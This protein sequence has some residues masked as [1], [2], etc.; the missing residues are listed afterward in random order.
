MKKFL[1]SLF[2]L[3]SL[4]VTAA[5]AGT[6]LLNN[7]TINNKK[8]V[9]AY[10]TLTTTGVY[11]S[12]AKYAG[13]ILTRNESGNLY[14]QFNNDNAAGRDFST[15]VSGG[16]AKTVKITWSTKKS[17]I[18]NRVVNIYGQNK[19]YT[20]EEEG[21][22]TLIGSA[23][24]G[25]DPSVTIDLSKTP[26]QYIA[27]NAPKLV[28]I[29]SI[30]IV[31][32]A[33]EKD[34]VPV[35]S[36]DVEVTYDPNSPT[37]DLSKNLPADLLSDAKANLNYSDVEGYV[38]TGGT[39]M[40]ATGTNPASVT[41]S[42]AET[43]KYKKGNHTFKV[44]IHKA[45]AALAYSAETATATM[46]EAAE[47]PT[48]SN[49]YNLKLRYSS[50]KRA[51][52]DID[53]NT[54]AVTIVAPG[55]ATIGAFFDGNELF[56]AGSA[57][58]TLT[59][60]EAGLPATPEFSFT[61]EGTY[62]IDQTL[63]IATASEDAEIYYTLDGENYIKYEGEISFDKAGAYTVSAYAKNAKGQSTTA[64]I[65]FTIELL[66]HAFSF[67]DAEGQMVARDRYFKTP[68]LVGAEGVNVVYDYTYNTGVLT[69]I[70]G[71][72]NEYFITGAGD[73]LVTATAAADAT[74]EAYSAKTTVTIVPE[75]IVGEAETTQE[76]DFVNYTKLGLDEVTPGNNV[77]IYLDAEPIVLGGVTMTFAKNSG[78]ERPRINV[79]TSNVYL[80]LYRESKTA[81]NGNGCSVTISAKDIT[82]IEMTV[83]NTSY[84]TYSV[85]TGS[86]SAISADKVYTWTPNAGETAQ[87]VEIKNIGKENPQITSIK[88]YCTAVTEVAGTTA[89]FDMAF[90]NEDGYELEV[91]DKLP[92]V[93][94][95]EG[96]SGKVNYLLGEELIS[97]PETFVFKEEHESY[98]LH[99]YTEG[100][101]NY[102]PAVA[103][104]L[105][106]VSDYEFE[107][108]LTIHYSTDEGMHYA[109]CQTVT[110]TDGRYEFKDIEVNGYDGVDG[111][112]YG[113]VFFSFYK[114][115]AEAAALAPR[116]EA[117]VVDWA[118]FN[119][120]N[121]IYTPEEHL[122]MAGANTTLVRNRANTLGET[123]PAV[124]RV[125]A[126]ND[127]QKALNFTV[128]LDKQGT[129]NVTV[130][131]GTQTGVESVGVDAD[132][133]AEYYTLQGVRVAK[134]AAGI[135][136]RRQG[137]TV[138][139]V[140]VK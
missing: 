139:K 81:T 69:A 110:G 99:A 94:L 68:A 129:S 117:A 107:G 3:L 63:A 32:A 88:V 136:L 22:G 42:W 33:A 126:T 105:V 47:L 125:P 35:T 79:G 62:K 121:V 140:L 13:H 78:T 101:E 104:T 123:M 83:K 113:H 137:G 87:S 112:Y 106:T 128:Q 66:K 120:A 26:F 44:T 27:I 31:W 89:T 1:L 45:E 20:G 111:K 2:L 96:F 28:Y 46:G 48:L 29:E 85:S 21:V 72:T 65:T 114:A 34:E 93:V 102:L 58:Y 14:L 95:P 119:A 135:Y 74:H 77:F 6:D 37:L 67:A 39:I 75:K 98:E 122:A 84:T 30:E 7:E 23:K 54:G 127:T 131:E 15:I 16:I 56:K 134:P 38:G 59:V 53:D 92:K 50:S 64:K 24:K 19:A 52:A 5:A 61:D 25:S 36:D 124:L 55:T 70:P 43:D 76:F 109:N 71:K 100:D 57:T 91:G 17:T 73:V 60:Q 130:S 40:S 116:R 41:V 118:S 82:K 8:D 18:N 12:G 4:A 11:P 49:P 51:V 133:E 108:H 90:D 9:S 80:G 97:N 86:L 132:G 10:A 103:Y 138:S 115:P